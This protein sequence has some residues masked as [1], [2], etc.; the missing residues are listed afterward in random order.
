M[1][2]PIAL[3][4]D[5]LRTVSE[6]F[7]PQTC[8]VSRYTETNTPDG[9][10]EAWSTV[11]T[12]IRCRVSTGAA[13][14]AVENAGS[15]GSLSLAVSEWTI[16]LPYDTDVTARDRLAVDPP[17]GRVFEVARVG[18]RSYEVVREVLCALVT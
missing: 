8:A 9:V 18:I 2:T 3:P 11:A 14:A 4:L 17:D 6:A 7:L 13:T 10:E 15:S 5:F 12:G 16:W 1:T